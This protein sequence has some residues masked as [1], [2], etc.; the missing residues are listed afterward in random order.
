M[1]L[2]LARFFFEDERLHNRSHQEGLSRVKTHENSIFLYKSPQADYAIKA[3]KIDYLMLFCLGGWVAGLHPFLIVPPAILLLSYPRR[4]T[5]F[6]FFTFHAEL[7]RHTELVVFHKT[8]VF[9]KVKRIYVDI[10]NLEKIDAEVVPATI[11]WKIN[12][13]DPDLVFRD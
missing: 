12:T 3:R 10:K 2:S 8:T 7:L 5:G 9:G 13:F 11:L 4:I 1:V 6:H